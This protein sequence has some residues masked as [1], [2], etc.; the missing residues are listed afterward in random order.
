MTFKQQLNLMAKLQEL[1]NTRDFFDEFGQIEQKIRVKG[2][3]P[4]IQNLVL[5]DVFKQSLERVYDTPDFPNC[6]RVIQTSIS[7]IETVKL[8]LM[9]LSISIE[10][11]GRTEFVKINVTPHET[12]KEEE[13][14]DLLDNLV[15]KLG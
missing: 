4:L 7:I 5:L 3:Y 1:E 14:K 6:H 8:K 13:K 10:G 2:E 9:N 11:A 12:E 15:D